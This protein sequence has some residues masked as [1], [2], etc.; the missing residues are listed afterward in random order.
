MRLET[1]E[2]TNA[3]KEDANPTSEGIEKALMERLSASPLLTLRMDIINKCNLRCIMCHY[4][5]PKFSIGRA[6]PV[7]ASQ[8]SGWLSSSG[9]YVRDIMLSC[10]DEPLMSKYFSEIITLAS[11]LSPS[12]SIGFCTNAMLM[13]S[14]IRSAIMKSRV[15]YILFS[16]DG[17]TPETFE[18]IRAGSS[19]EKVFSN[20]KSLKTLKNSIGNDE[21]RFV[22]N[23]VMMRS[24]IHEAPSIVEIAQDLGVDWV[25]FRHVVPHPPFWNDESEMLQS[26][27]GVFNYY[28]SRVVEES[29]KLKIPVFIPEPF[30]T[31]HEYL[32]TEECNVDLS[33]Y[34]TIQSEKVSDDELLEIR[35]SSPKKTALSG[36]DLQGEFFG[37]AFCERP[38]T[39]IL[40]RNQKEV[41]PCAWHKKI[42]GMLD[43]DTTLES[44][45]FGESFSHLRLKMMRGELDEGCIGCPVKSGHLPTRVATE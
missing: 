41:L 30:A 35:K 29:A 4:S 40:I 32:P 2:N 24:N 10:G 36:V 44:I 15:S 28:R 5:D 8:F 27:P 39:E 25:D 6:Q 22:L 12:A 38:F 9:K 23:F 7:T 31:S 26:S 13:T 18:R 17:A 1:F 34:Y 19:Y 3:M 20:I 14:R 42:L 11:D 33:R 45:F 43:G 21:P 37:S 16:V